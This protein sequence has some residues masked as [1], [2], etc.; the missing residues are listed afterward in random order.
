MTTV[1]LSGTFSEKQKANNGLTKVAALIRKDR[2]VRVPIVGWI[3]YHQWTEKLT[4]DVLTVAVPVVEAVVD[5]DGKDTHGWGEAVM[6]MIDELR[7]ERGLGSA[8]E[9]PFHSGE[10]GGQIEFDF[11]GDGHPVVPEAETR[12]GPDGE[13]VVPEPSGEEILAERE[14]AKADVPAATFSGGQA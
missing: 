1:N 6:D 13:H 7:K 11:D 5:S 4:G 9:V 12:L 10:L 3:E 14:E 2:T 8:H